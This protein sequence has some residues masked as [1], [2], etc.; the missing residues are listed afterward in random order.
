MSGRFKSF[1][2]MQNHF[3]SWHKVT[4][5]VSTDITLM[6]LLQYL[7]MFYLLYV[8][9]ELEIATQKS[10][11]KKVLLKIPQNLRSLLQ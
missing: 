6:A 2:N 4:N 1:L 11:I 7:D 3:Q 5:I 10:S 9:E 8:L